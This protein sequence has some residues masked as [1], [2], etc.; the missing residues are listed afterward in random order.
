[1]KST[2]FFLLRLAVSIILI[3]YFA[4][5]VDI[6][7]AFTSIQSLGW[8]YIALTALIVNLDRILM[9]YKWNIL[10]RAKNIE[11]S[12]VEAIRSYY[13]GT[14]WGS[15]LPAS[16]GGDV[17]RVY[18]ITRQT[19]NIEDIASSV[20]LERVLGTA[21]ALLVAM[22]S[23]GLFV[24][25]AHFGSWKMIVGLILS[26]FLF[27]ALVALSFNTRLNHWFDQRLR[28]LNHDW[29]RKVSEFYRSYQAYRH[30]RGPM[31]RFSLWSLLEQCLPIICAF[32]V[33]Q[34][35]N[36]RI[37]FW[38]F[39]I[40]IP[41]ILAL[42]RMPISLDGFGVREGLYVYFFS[43]VG[44]PTT[45][46]FILGFLSHIIGT[47]SIIPGFFFYSIFPPLSVIDPTES[48]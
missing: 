15:F 40:F 25:L 38:S 16:V 2:F 23:M 13:I 21:T 9:S 35:L 17:V 3:A 33:S 19:N 30:H 26:F 37:P 10:L 18:R 20:V 34:A 8:L 28:V 47:I 46:A 22:L 12:F 32:L 31:L 6:T 39:V 5:S 11:V 27:I 36:L 4:S 44:V 1:M 41:L 42:S 45:E 7:R 48:A 24:T 14:F 43:L 29:T